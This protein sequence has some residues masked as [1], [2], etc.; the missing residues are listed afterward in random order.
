MITKKE[1]LRRI[2][3]LHST[4]ENI[5][6][7]DELYNKIM[8]SYQDSK[9]LINQQ[10]LEYDKKIVQNSALID[11][12]LNEFRSKIDLAIDETFNSSK[13]WLDEQRLN[14]EKY[15][16]DAKEKLSEL[17]NE[18]VISNESVLVSK[19]KEISIKLDEFI[20]KQ[21]TTWDNKIEEITLEVKS[22]LDKHA[23][24]LNELINSIVNKNIQQILID[25]ISAKASENILHSFN[26]S[27]VELKQP[28]VESI[29]SL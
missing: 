9:A 11:N 21:A 23:L 22:V 18:I 7:F 6:N 5:T 26:K 16:Q 29:L 13:K 12:R 28:E 1:L 19:E 14:F 25:D 4:Y 2:E 17:S 3:N 8:E 20:N 15:T 24:N 10:I 27:L